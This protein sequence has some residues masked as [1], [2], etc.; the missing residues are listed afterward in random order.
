MVIG[1]SVVAI[2][3]TIVFL[4]RSEF[5]IVVRAILQNRV[6]ASVNGVNAARYSLWAFGLGAAIAAVAGVLLAPSTNVLPYMG[7]TY[8]A[9]AFVA[10]IL[11]GAGRP[12]GVL[13]GAAFMAGLEVTFGAFV[14]PTF[15]R[16]AVLILAIIAIRIRPEGLLRERKGR[17]A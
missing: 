16:A 8:L 9:P 10:V 11:G 7:A 15:A 12:G 14:G 5:G 2:T 6:A 3:A 13:I 17:F 1:I 4:A